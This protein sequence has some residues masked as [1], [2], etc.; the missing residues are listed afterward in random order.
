MPPQR[1]TPRSRSASASAASAV[2]AS[3][4]S[5][6]PSKRASSIVSRRRLGR[7]AGGGKAA[8]L[9]AV[10]DDRW[11]GTTIGNGLRPSDWPTSRAVASGPTR[12]RGGIAETR[13]GAIAR[14][15]AYTRRSK[16]SSRRMSSGSR[17]DRLRSPRSKQR[18]RRWRR[19]CLGR[20]RLD[21]LRKPLAIR[22]AV[23]PPSS[24]AA[25]PRTRRPRSR[26]ARNRRSRWRSEGKGSRIAGIVPWCGTTAGRFGRVDPSRIGA[27]G[28]S[29]TAASALGEGGR[30]TIGTCSPTR[31]S[32]AAGSVAASS[33]GPHARVL[34][35]HVTGQRHWDLPKGGIH[36]GETPA[37]AALRETMEETGLIFAPAAL[38][39]LG[40]PP[41]PARRTCIS[42]AAPSDRVDPR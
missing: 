34:L 42:F 13:P 40:R 27:A 9:A 28:D 31:F 38:V 21:R 25:T 18:S 30:E 36:A 32:V 29:P 35:C 3:N 17:R 15:A 26:R 23:A 5:G 2:D 6:G 24:R 33:L 14:A 11:Q 39:D 41:T 4:R 37:E 8:Q 1:R 19:R 16:G 10:G 12:G 7:A 22:A 20:A